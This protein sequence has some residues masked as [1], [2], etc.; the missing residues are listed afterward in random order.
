MVSDSINEIQ[1]AI[2]NKDIPALEQSLKQVP[3]YGIFGYEA[4]LLLRCAIDSNDVNILS[5]LIQARCNISSAFVV[6]SSLF[7]L[8]SFQQ[9]NL[10]QNM[11]TVQN[12]VTQEI[13]VFNSKSVVCFSFTSGSCCSSSSRLFLKRT[14]TTSPRMLRV[15][16]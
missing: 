15:P 1:T 3:K 14:T 7:F 11:S 6:F 8:Y 4:D 5:M 2:K 10:C 12:D 13:Y 16:T 9:D